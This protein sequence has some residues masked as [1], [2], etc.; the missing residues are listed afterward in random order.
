MKP[1]G[2]NPTGIGEWYE[3]NVRYTGDRYGV[4]LAYANGKIYTMGGGCST[5]LTSNRHYQTT[6]KSQPQV[7][8]YSRMIDTDTDVFPNSWLMNGV[9]N[10]IGSRWQMSYQT[11]NDQDGIPTDCGTADMTTWGQVTNFGNVTLGDVASYTPKDGSG[12][13]ISCARFYFFT[14][15]ID[16]SN[17]FGY[18]EDVTRGPTI[19]DLSLFFTSDPSKR[20]R[21]GKTFTGGEQQPLDTPCRQSVDADCPLP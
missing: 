9:D 8:K 6:V 2:N 17:T 12:N 19:S 16:A 21:H 15:S 11:M 7:A 10:S 4:A 1:S 20:L 18:P 3:T 5:I 14:V 13:N